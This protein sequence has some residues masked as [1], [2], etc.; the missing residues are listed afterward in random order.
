VGGA[1]AAETQLLSFHTTSKGAF[2]ECGLRGGM[3][4]AHIEKKE[5][6]TDVAIIYQNFVFRARA[7]YFRLY[8]NTSSPLY[9][10]FIPPSTTIT[11]GDDE[12]A[13][14]RRGASLQNGL[15]QPELQRHR[16]GSKKC[17]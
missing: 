6:P 3:V 13:R 11:G 2:G 8:F 16:P 5:E 1:A 12:R 4:G 14:G 7:F 17:S 15:H 10:S 9:S